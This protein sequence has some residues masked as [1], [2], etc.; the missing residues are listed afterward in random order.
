MLRSV[1]GIAAC[2]TA[3]DLPRTRTCRWVEARTLGHAGHVLRAL[4]EKVHQ[5]R[6]AALLP[7]DAAP[8]ACQRAPAR[9]AC[10]LCIPA[11]Q[12][13]HRLPVLPVGCSQA[14]RAAP[15]CMSHQAAES[16]AGCA[17]PCQSQCPD[18]TCYV[19]AVCTPAV[20]LS[21]TQLA[22]QCRRRLY[23]QAR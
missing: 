13:T 14:A 6:I 22:V 15:S 16:Q 17:P 5:A 18:Q 23:V 10:C 9:A 3:E 19:A 21:Q 7:D 8:A 11:C 20:R 2:L 4:G 1:Q 12:Q